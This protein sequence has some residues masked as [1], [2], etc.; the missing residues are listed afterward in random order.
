MIN[1]NYCWLRADPWLCGWVLS[2]CVKGLSELEKSQ[3]S[4]CLKG[5]LGKGCICRRL[6]SQHSQLL[7]GVAASAAAHGV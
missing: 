2:L 3:S 4:C 1:F 5:V 6:S 7:D